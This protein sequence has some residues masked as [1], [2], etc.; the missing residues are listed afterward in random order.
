MRKHTTMK[1]GQIALLLESICTS[2]NVLKPIGYNYMRHSV[3]R[4]LAGATSL[5]GEK[6]HGLHDLWLTLQ[7]IRRQQHGPGYTFSTLDKELSK[8]VSELFLRL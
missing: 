1:S 2:K 5:G 4:F 3:V 6:T 7:P 8:R